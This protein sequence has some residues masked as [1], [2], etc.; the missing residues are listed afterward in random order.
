MSLCLLPMITT[1]LELQSA[2][3][4]KQSD[5]RGLVTV[6]PLPIHQHFNCVHTRLQSG[7]A[8]GHLQSTQRGLVTVFLK[9]CQRI[10]MPPVEAV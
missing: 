7:W 10:G 1:C 5:L 9:G 4:G 2:K 3:F 8:D 6:R